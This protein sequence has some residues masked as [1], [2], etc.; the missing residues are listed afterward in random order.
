M[1]H[2]SRQQPWES[3]E[4]EMHPLPP[5]TASAK[6]YPMPT[7]QEQCMGRTPTG[8]QQIAGMAAQAGNRPS[9]SAGLPEPGEANP[10]TVGA[11]EQGGDTVPRPD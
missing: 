5:P 11:A 1:P 10:E 8:L 2:Y 9:H 3:H 7:L 4:E 6:S